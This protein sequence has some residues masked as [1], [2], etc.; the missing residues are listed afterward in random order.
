M[1][2]RADIDTERMDDISLLMARMYRM[3]PPLLLE[4]HF[5]M[6]GNRGGLTMVWTA[7]V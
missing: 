7:V 4:C 1:T 3:R 6:H 2:E 5:P